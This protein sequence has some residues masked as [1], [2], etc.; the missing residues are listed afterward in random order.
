MKWLIFLLTLFSPINA[1]ALVDSSATTET[2]AL[3]TQLQNA[4][5]NYI[6]FGQHF[7]D[8][9]YVAVSNC[10]VFKI[11]G[12]YPY[13]TE[14]A[15]KIGWR[16]DP[17]TTT[18]NNSFLE[19]IKR[20][21]RNRGIIALSFIHANMVTNG[22]TSD[23]TGDPV[24]NIL[25]GGSQR[26]KY[27]LHLD[28][29]AAWLNNL[30][31]DN[32]NLIPIIIRPY[33]ENDGTWFWWGSSNCTIAQYVALFQDFVDYLISKNV[34]NAIYCYA[35]EFQFGDGAS[36]ARYPGDLYVDIQ[37]VDQYTTHA[38]DSLVYV[39]DAYDFAI[40]HNKIFA[41]T[42][43]GGGTSGGWIDGRLPEVDFWT[44]YWLNPVLTD[45]KANKASYIL[46]WKSPKWGPDYDRSDAP[47]FLEMSQ[48]PK[49]KML[50][51][52]NNHIYNATIRN[53][54]FN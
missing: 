46:I 29:L 17:V 50:Q 4:Q 21:Y 42:E 36:E 33:H 13:V 51:Y 11:T 37:G 8:G 52:Y 22:P 7:T 20:C 47:S 3:Y 45:N 12:K 27:L 38:Q 30:K 23:K 43:F 2:Q 48:N 18:Y 14:Y 34:H 16:T 26:D 39:D 5:G 53:A 15:Y 25:P 1:M 44:T 6:Y 54:T 40:L 9:S 19:D 10:D 24:L 49:I 35:P 41:I 31:D 32:G 28:D